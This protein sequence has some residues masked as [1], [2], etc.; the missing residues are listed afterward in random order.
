MSAVF[1]FFMDY[2]KK[3]ITV[4]TEAGD[5]GLSIKKITRHVYNASNSFFDTVD[6]DDV[7]RYVSLFL[8]RNSKNNESFIEKSTKRG[9][10]HINN[11][12]KEFKQLMLEYGGKE[13]EE[14]NTDVKQKVDQSLSLF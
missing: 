9:I 7:H 2:D 4:L 5:E 13:F 3:I 10:Y 8:K 11:K 14:D 6:I 12:S 1:L